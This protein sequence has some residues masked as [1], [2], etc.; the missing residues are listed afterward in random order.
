[1]S[2]TIYY[3]TGCHYCHKLM[4]IMQKNQVEGNLVDI[5]TLHPRD[6]KRIKFV[7]VMVLP[8]GRK[9]SGQQLFDWA[10]RGGFG[11]RQQRHQQ[12]H[13]YHQHQYQQ[14]QQ[15]GQYQGQQEHFRGQGRGDDDGSGV[16]GWT[17]GGGGL[18]FSSIG[19]ESY[20]QHHEPFSYI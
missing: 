15:Q 4:T 5:E 8:D 3:S 14:G 11:R 7:P 10:E 2:A 13:Q 9:V 12:Q 20:V 1:M 16:G 19:T 17:G 18:E 6:A